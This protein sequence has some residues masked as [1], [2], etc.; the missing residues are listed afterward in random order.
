MLN[1]V[2]CSG[3][4]DGGGHKARPPPLPPRPARLCVVVYKDCF[5]FRD[6]FCA[7]VCASILR[8]CAEMIICC[9]FF[10]APVFAFVHQVKPVFDR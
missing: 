5:H 1:G 3:W 8:Y 10:F 9:C 2:V 6:V 7:N 4:M